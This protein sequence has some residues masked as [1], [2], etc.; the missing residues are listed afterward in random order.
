MSPMENLLNTQISIIILI[1][2][3]YCLTKWKLMSADFRKSMNNL[4]IN[5][6]LPCNIIKSFLTESSNAILKSC[7]AVFAVSAVTQAAVF[8]LGKVLYARVDKDKR[9]SLQYG[10]MVSNAGFLGN[11]I[12]EGLYGAQGL[13]YASVYLIPQRIM[14]WSVG[15][16]CFTE[17]NGKGAVKKALTHPCIIAVVIGLVLMLTKL[18]LPAWVETPVNLVGSCN[19]ALSLIVIGGILAEIDPRSIISKVSLWYCLIRLA[20]IPLLV[21]AGCMLAGVD[22]LV[23]ETSTVLAGMPA[24]I[25]TAILASQYNRNEKFAVSLVFLSTVLS[26]ITIPLLC[27]LMMVIYQL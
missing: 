7:V 6:I 16:A 20:V 8:F 4:I 17:S 26:M 2:A 9:S 25:T 15:V 23:M 10:T 11:P 12:V 19:T 22:R 14:M 27:V 21:M 1:L 3:G 13:L 18:P 5:F 24:A